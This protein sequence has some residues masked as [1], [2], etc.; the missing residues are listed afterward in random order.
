MRLAEGEADSKELSD[1]ASSN[2]EPLEIFPSVTLPVA[3]IGR[4]VALKLLARDD[5]SRPQDAIDLRDRKFKTG[6]HPTQSQ[7]SIF[8]FLFPV[9]CFS[10]S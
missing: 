2:S 6:Q 7:L 9:S 10:F 3:Q 8:G 1:A 5:R 4:L